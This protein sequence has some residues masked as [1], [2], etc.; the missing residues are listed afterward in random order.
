MVEWKKLIQVW[1]HNENRGYGVDEQGVRRLNRRTWS[2]WNTVIK[3]GLVRLKL[4]ISSKGTTDAVNMC[5]K[6]KPLLKGV[7][8]LLFP[9]G[10]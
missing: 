6:G 3:N 8:G 10:I 9:Y 2:D 7:P 1:Q 5:N 4:M